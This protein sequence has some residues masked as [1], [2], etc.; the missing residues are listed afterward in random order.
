VFETEDYS[1][2]LPSMT[3]NFEI[4]PDMKLRFGAA[5]TLSRARMDYLSASSNAGVSDVADIET[6]S[7]FSGEGGN[8]RLRPY[9]ANGFDLSYEW[10]WWRRI[11]RNRRLLRI[12]GRFREPECIGGPRLQLPATDPVAA[13]ARFCRCDYLSRT[14]E[15]AGQPGR[16]LHPRDRPFSRLRS[17]ISVEPSAPAPRIT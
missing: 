3:L 16:R 15:R 8:P 11:F 7:I 6:G 13:A 12:A 14:G 4:A 17:R 2:I 5:R 1:H 10:Y 9:I